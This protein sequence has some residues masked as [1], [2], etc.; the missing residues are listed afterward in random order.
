MNEAERVWSRIKLT[1]R[2]LAATGRPLTQERADELTGCI[3]RSEQAERPADNALVCLAN[4]LR[5]FV[6]QYQKERFP[7]PSEIAVMGAARF[8]ITASRRGTTLY[9]TV[10]ANV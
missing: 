10:A 5:S 9:A 2:K 1:A 8:V 4:E 6:A 7:M 3:I